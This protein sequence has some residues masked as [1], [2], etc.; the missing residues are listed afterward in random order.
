M[1]FR[2]EYQTYLLIVI[3]IIIAG[4]FLKHFFFNKKKKVIEGQG[5]ATTY[6]KTYYRINF[7]TDFNPA[8]TLPQQDLLK[9]L[10]LSQYT[11]AEINTDDT[12]NKYVRPAAEY[13]PLIPESLFSKNSSNGAIIVVPLCDNRL[14]YFKQQAAA[15]DTGDATAAAA[16]YDY[17][18][19]I[20]SNKPAYK[21][22]VNIMALIAAANLFTIVG[23]PTINI[24]DAVVTT[25]R[26]AV[27]ATLTNMGYTYALAA[28]ADAGDFF[29]SDAA[30]A[31]FITNITVNLS[32]F[33]EAYKKVLSNTI[34]LSN[35]NTL[36]YTDAASEEKSDI[37]SEYSSEFKASVVNAI[38]AEIGLD[39]KAIF[40]DATGVAFF[41]AFAAANLD[42][43]LIL[44]DLPNPWRPNPT[45]P[46]TSTTPPTKPLT[47]DAIPVDLYAAVAAT[48][49]T[50]AT[51]AYAVAFADAYA[52][53]LT[54]TSANITDN[55]NYK[56]VINKYDKEALI[57]AAGLI[58]Q[59]ISL[60][61]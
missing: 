10:I 27:I 45:E 6:A 46:P 36:S 37:E 26:N 50:V 33:I 1:K 52:K 41:G 57:T 60:K 28:A 34:A 5:G 12:G 23:Q 32:D 22:D 48:Y 13:I 42:A 11:T 14:E 39:S 24:T 4:Y 35:T 51:L 2:K 58:Y 15:A 17:A 18:R 54:L 7:P 21:A 47:I 29:V 25:A 3:A 9:E 30:K 38:L 16:A 20:L 43:L 31:T 61:L 59:S 56:K 53:G 49:A 40:S 19:L 55:A 44:A 8:L